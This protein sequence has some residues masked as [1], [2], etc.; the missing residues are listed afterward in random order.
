MALRPIGARGISATY[1]HKTPRIKFTLAMKVTGLLYLQVIGPLLRF[2]Y[3][4]MVLSKIFPQLRS[5]C[6]DG[7]GG[8]GHLCASE[9]R[10]PR[11]ESK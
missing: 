2:H 9:R 5:C 10:P 11:L 6:C 7:A 4:R 3:D 1:A 8:R